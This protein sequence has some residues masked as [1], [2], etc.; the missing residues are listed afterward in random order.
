MIKTK[1]AEILTG[2]NRKQLS[3]IYNERIYNLV[4]CEKIGNRLYFE[5][6][7]LLDYLSNHQEIKRH[8]YAEIDAMP[9]KPFFLLTEYGYLYATTQDASVYNLTM[10]TR[11]QPAINSSGRRVVGIKLRGGEF[12]NLEVSRLV[13]E[14]QVQNNLRKRVIHHLDTNILNDTAPNLLPVTSKEH[15]QLHRYLN[16]GQT[17]DYDYLVNKIRAEN[18]QPIYEIPHPEFEDNGIYRFGYEVTREGFDAFRTNKPIPVNSIILE[19]AK[20]KTG[21]RETE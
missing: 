18:S 19:F 13:A 20:I 14:S 7:S 3:K 10:G 5:P 1:D 12:R 8:F 15:G 11:L 16:S 2:L 6:E 9:N 17:E 4:V 21:K